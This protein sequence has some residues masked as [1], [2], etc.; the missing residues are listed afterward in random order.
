MPFSE[1]ANRLQGEK[2]RLRASERE[3]LSLFV[4]W[5]QEEVNQLGY[6]VCDNSPCFL[7]SC[8]N[9]PVGGT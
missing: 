2:V 8:M 9:L 7:R 3:D 6:N 4:R 5:L 1:E